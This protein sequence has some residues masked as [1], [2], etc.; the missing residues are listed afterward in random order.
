MTKTVFYQD[1]H[2]AETVQALPVETGLPEVRFNGHEW[3]FANSGLSV[4]AAPVAPS[5]PDAPLLA[6]LED[7]SV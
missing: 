3:V 4:Y 2:G 6:A 5:E 7:L 1:R